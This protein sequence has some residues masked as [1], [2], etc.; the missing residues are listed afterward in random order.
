MFLLLLL[1]LQWM[2]P[3]SFQSESAC[4]AATEAVSAVSH[5]YAVDRQ[6]VGA[7]V[8]SSCHLP[9]DMTGSAPTFWSDVRFVAQPD[10]WLWLGDNIY[11]D[12]E[13]MNA[14]RR[15]YNRVRENNLYRHDGP[16]SETK[17]KIPIMATWDDHDY[18]YNNAGNE[19]ACPDQS[20]AEWANHVNMPP[21]EPQHPDSPDYRLGVYNS[22]MF[23]KPGSP[24]NGLHVIMLDA[25]SGRDPTFS[26]AGVCKGSATRILTNTQWT[27]LEQELERESEIKIIG[28]GIQ[29]LPPTDQQSRSV[30]EYC[31]HDS[32]K[33]DGN[34]NTFLESIA[35]LGEDEQWY[36]VQYEMWGEVPLEREKLLGLAQRSINRGKS[37][38]VI[39]VSGDQ[40]WA[41]LMA[42]RMPE[43]EEWGPTQV[44]YEVTAS[45]VPRNWPYTEANSNRLRGRS[46]DHQGWGPFNQNC[47][48]PFIYGGETY[49]DCTPV[50]N[51]GVGWCSVRVDQAGNHQSGYWG[52]CGP[53]EQELGQL[54]FS[55]STQTC[56]DTFY[57]CSAKANYGYVRVDFDSQRLEMG[58]R[59]PEEEEVMSHQVNY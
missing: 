28:S 49:T 17:G 36:G 43:S 26:S 55:N 13:D 14:K 24:E 48:F 10:L 54:A 29:V 6:E 30:S 2:I 31:A 12:G 51:E 52:N 42:K 53:P 38:A 34:T 39:F 4:K 41:E 16:V 32:H 25:R 11:Q 3:A 23:A 40:H 22:R 58:V 50:N 47:Q 57:I 5:T 44:L 8:F 21:T 59:T 18:G 7:V 56:S 20:Q 35:R 19:Y 1:L 9:D 45:G 37:K 33:W 15:E 27:W 46:A